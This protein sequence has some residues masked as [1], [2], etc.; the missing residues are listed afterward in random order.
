MCLAPTGEWRAKNVA[1]MRA[2]PR[3]QI[4]PRAAENNVAPPATA[5]MPP[6]HAHR[7]QPL[8]RV[9]ARSE[10]AFANHS[11]PRAIRRP[12]FR[13]PPREIARAA[14]NSQLARS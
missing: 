9:A 7:P 6:T 11:E 5:A 4:K 14:I 2:Q 13:F 12:L 1:K 3:Q 10:F 8:R